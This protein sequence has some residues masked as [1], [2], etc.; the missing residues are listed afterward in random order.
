MHRVLVVPWSSAAAYFA[1]VCVSLCS[2]VG[3]AG[4]LGG[5]LE[6]EVGRRRPRVL[7]AGAALAEV[8]RAALARHHRHGGLHALLG[9]LRRLPERRGDVVAVR[10]AQRL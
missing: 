9:G 4:G 6:Q 1:T 3:L 8:A 10:C 7:V 2:S 5:A